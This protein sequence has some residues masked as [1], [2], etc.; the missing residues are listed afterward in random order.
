MF[1]NSTVSEE[2]CVCVCVCCYKV[3]LVYIVSTEPQGEGSLK[4]KLRNNVCV[5]YSENRKQ[6]QLFTFH[7]MMHVCFLTNKIFFFF[8]F[9]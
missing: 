1:R 9:F 5:C 3:P 7:I 6:T 8:L 4:T 2:M